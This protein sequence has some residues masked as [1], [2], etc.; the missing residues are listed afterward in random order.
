MFNGRY[1]SEDPPIAG[2]KGTEIMHTVFLSEDPIQIELPLYES[3]QMQVVEIEVLK[4]IRE[5]HN[6]AHFERLPSC[7]LCLEKLDSAVSG[8]QQ[9]PSL[10]GLKSS[11]TADTNMGD[12]C[13]P[14]VADECTVC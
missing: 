10:I 3:P 12:K 8:L 5:R 7:P 6:G 1:F 14:G 2:G 9:A 4:S 13:W 11:K